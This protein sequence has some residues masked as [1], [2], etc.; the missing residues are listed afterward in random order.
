MS[1]GNQSPNKTKA[2]TPTRNRGLL[3]VAAATI[4]AAVSITAAVILRPSGGPTATDVVSD[5]LN[6]LAAGDAQTAL[7][8]SAATPGSTALLVDDVLN[9]QLKKAPITDIHVDGVVTTMNS[10]TGR[11]FVR[12]SARFG[13]QP[14]TATIALVRSGGSWKLASSFLVADDPGHGIGGN[15]GRAFDTLEVFGVPVGNS[16]NFSVFPGAL[17]LSTSNPF[18]DVTQSPGLSLERLRYGDQPIP[19]NPVFSLNENGKRAVRDAVTDW[20]T[21]CYTPGA[22][23]SGPCGKLDPTRGGQYVAGTSRLS[24]PIDF[25]QWT[26]TLDQSLRVVAANMNARVPVTSQRP[27]GS[28]DNWYWVGFTTPVDISQN[29]PVV[30]P[31]Q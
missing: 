20:V 14:T 22:T 28:S 13:A 25:G 27:D 10:P 4:V 9:Q 19:F 16:G 24:G 29:P 6:A 5:Y 15:I 26:Y 17:S 1:Y 2:L 3:A 23:P 8:L 11:I 12:A 31:P 7:R 30:L 21:A 18:L